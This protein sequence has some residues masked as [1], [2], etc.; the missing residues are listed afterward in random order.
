MRNRLLALLFLSTLPYAAQAA[1]AEWQITPR[2][3][4][5]D[6]DVKR[7]YTGVNGSRT[8]ADLYGVGCGVGYLMP[9]GMVV[10]IGADFGAE[11]DLFNAL[12]NYSL[13]Q[14]FVAVG[15]QF[16]LGE[17]WRFVPKFGRARWRL[18]SE[19]GV[20]LNPGPEDKDVLEGYDYYWE[21][22]V[23]RRISRVVALGVDY[24]QADYRFG[25]A[26]SASFLVTMGF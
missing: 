1:E 9:F 17:G 19:E 5:G 21:A 6:A 8:D 13:D 23:S 15:Y 12:D 7:E 18:Q 4:L 14:Q 3:L 20:F 26:R 2:A 11:F 24:K 10:E 25:R 22:S 16:E